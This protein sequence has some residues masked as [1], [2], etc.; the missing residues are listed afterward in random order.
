MSTSPKTSPKEHRKI[1]FRC[2]K[3]DYDYVRIIKDPRAEITRQRSDSECPEC[4]KEWE[5]G[6]EKDGLCWEEGCSET[7]PKYDGL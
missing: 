1:T 5:E 7:C 4:L 6:H 3:H 2:D